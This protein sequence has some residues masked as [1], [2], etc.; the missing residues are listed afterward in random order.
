[1]NIWIFNH[2]AVTPNSTGGTR[3][4]DMA[5]QL[6][7]LGYN[8]T[9]FSCSFNHFTK[10]E[11]HF[12]R[13]EKEFYKIECIDGV[14]FVW[15]RSNSYSKND[16]RR[17]SNMLLYSFRAYRAQKKID[18][19]PNV[20]IGS[21]VHPLAAVLGYYVAKKRSC[22]FYFEERDLWPQT[23]IDIGN[24]SPNNPLIKA[25]RFV[26]EFLIRRS[27]RVIVL[28]QKAV[29]YIES[30]GFSRDKVVYLPNGVDLENRQE[31]KISE[32]HK[33]VFDSLDG[34][35][36]A[37]YTGTHGLAN[38][39]HLLLEV[40]QLLKEE[41]VHF[42][43]IG[44][45][46]LKGDLIKQAEDKELSNICFLDPVPKIEVPGILE[47]AHVGL[48]ALNNSPLYKWGISLNKMFD[49]LASKLPVLVLGEVNDPIFEN[50]R[51]VQKFNNPKQLAKKII[52]LSKNRELLEQLS[53]EAYDYVVKNHSW[54]TLSEKLASVIH[55][56]VYRNEK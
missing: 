43:F 34:K 11:E 25:L 37:I 27:K 31:I 54:A 26:E 35:L 19:A 40:A 13:F 53:V 51:S 5:R 8:V 52:E 44:D 15:I 55:E 36:I 7:K 14:R 45:G 32:F 46:P 21:L 23:L 2:Y 41:N 47:R 17:I 20:V 42:V 12:T 3:H 30:K 33:Q 50:N 9:V 16:F 48:I 39:M 4:I 10:K 22:I 24:F 49:Y 18:E 38:Q 6:T 28:F 1:M 56:D 29:D